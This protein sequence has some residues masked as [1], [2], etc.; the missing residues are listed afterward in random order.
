MKDYLCFKCGWKMVKTIGVPVLTVFHQND[1]PKSEEELKSLKMKH[2]NLAFLKDNTN[3]I[4]GTDTSMP[5]G[6]VQWKG[7]KLKC[8]NPDCGHTW[9]PNR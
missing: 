5:I 9:E 7:T 1:L 8:T 4:Q 2:P 3:S 6:A